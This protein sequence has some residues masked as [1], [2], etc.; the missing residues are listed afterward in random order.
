MIACERNE[1]NE[2]YK[3]WDADE[4]GFDR[5]SRIYKEQFLNNL[6]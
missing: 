2:K 5:F 3:K 6:R 4:R 1:R